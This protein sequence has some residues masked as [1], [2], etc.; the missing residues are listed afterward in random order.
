MYSRI[1]VPI[2]TTSESD[3][4]VKTQLTTACEI[5]QK[6]GGLIH[7]MSVIPRN[8]LEGYYPD[9]YTNRVAERVREKLE[10]IVQRDCPSN[11]RVEMS[12]AEGSIYSN[13]LGVARELPA[14]AIVIASREPMLK[15]YVLG[16]TAA[17]IALH[18]PCAV[19]VVRESQTETSGRFL[20]YTPARREE[21]PNRLSA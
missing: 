3:D 21:R 2:D 10:A 17:H 5:A 20:K 7:V 14:D 19:L 9:L 11:A 4:G 12:V 1:L 13:I 16:S 6:P 18:A 15:D 8:L